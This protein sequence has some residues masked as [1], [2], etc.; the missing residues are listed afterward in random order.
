MN[1]ADAMERAKVFEWDLQRHLAPLLKSVVPRKGIYDPQFIAPNQAQRADHT[2]GGTKQQKMDQ[3]RADIDDFK[4]K[5]GVDKVVVLWTANTERYGE[6][7]AGLNDTEDALRT[8]I[9]NDEDEVSPS[10]L[11]A[12]A[13]VDEG[14][15]WAFPKS[16]DDCFKP[17]FDVH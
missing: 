9:A 16:A 14:T 7:S 10:T 5:S 6:I 3:I 15:R 2:I 12:L 11:Y 8:S 4:K 13:C 1:M 17:L